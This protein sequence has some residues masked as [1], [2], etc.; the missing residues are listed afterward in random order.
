MSLKK[1][2][3]SGVRWTAFSA[4]GRAAIQFGQLAVL[5]HL[6]VPEDF[7]L[8]AVVIATMAF[9]QIFSDAGISNAII[10]FQDISSEQLS[11]LYWLNVVVSVV[12]AALLACS[13]HWIAMWYGHL[14]IQFLLLLT[15][16]TLIFGALSQQIRIVAQKE[17]RFS[18][19]AKIDIASVLLG[20]VV[21]IT[22]AV[23]DAGV[24]S[25]VV[26]GLASSILGCCLLWGYMSNGWRPM[27]RLRLGEIE[28]FLSYGFYMVGNNLVSMFNSQID[29]LLGGRLIG[30]H[31][32]GLYSVPKELSLRISGIINPIVTQV[33]LPVMAKSQDDKALLKTIYL[34]TMLM[35]ASINCPIYIALVIFSPVLVPMIFGDKWQGSVVLLQIFAVYGL[36]RSLG[37]PA[38]SLLFAVGKAKLAFKWNVALLFLVPPSIW[39]GSWY[40]AEGM[41]YAM[42]ALMAVLYVPGWYFLIRPCCGVKLSEYFL[43]LLVPLMVAIISAMPVYFLSPLIANDLMRLI[44]GGGVF[45]LSYCALSFFLNKIWLVSMLELLAVDKIKYLFRK[46]S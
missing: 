36:L 34:K 44:L 18:G 6:L 13:S 31:D 42:L 45:G 15:S 19:L 43:Q 28:K 35:T 38:G 37:N 17:L 26:G 39:V 3:F 9:I 16:I 40:G 5:A 27:L 12:L 11:S 10:H 20:F 24:F 25:L 30:M 32:L 23:N 2:T 41:A 7:G 33:G 29:V 4:F 46:K 14:E 22:F 1:Q 21:A 8:M